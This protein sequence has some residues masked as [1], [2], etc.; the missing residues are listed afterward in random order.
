MTRPPSKE[1]SKDQE[2]IQSSNTPSPEHYMQKRQN[3][4]KHHTQE[5]KEASHFP[6]GDHKSAKNIKDSTTNKRTM[7]QQKGTRVGTVSKTYWRA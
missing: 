7:I 2:S 3:T 1:E 6:A 4:R 5:S